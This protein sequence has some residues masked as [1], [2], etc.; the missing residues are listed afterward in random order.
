MSGLRNFLNSRTAKRRNERVNDIDTFKEMKKL[1]AIRGVI[2][3][4]LIDGAEHSKGRVIINPIELRGFMPKDF[5]SLSEDELFKLVLKATIQ[6][7]EEEDLDY[8]IEK[9][10]GFERYRIYV[11]WVDEEVSIFDILDRD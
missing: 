5:Y 7:A 10:G 6:I 11:S 9:V 3:S 2:Y 4:K 8:S 1:K